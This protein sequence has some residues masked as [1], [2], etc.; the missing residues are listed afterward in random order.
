[1]PFGDGTGP[2]KKG[3][4]GRGMGVG[5]G[6]GLHRRFGLHTVNRKSVSF[7]S[8]TSLENNELATEIYQYLPKINCGAC[9]YPTCMACAIAIAKGEAPYNVCKVLKPEQHSKIKEVMERRR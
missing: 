1:M 4:F 7:P 5:K 3:D 6:R 9:G 2:Y 8:E